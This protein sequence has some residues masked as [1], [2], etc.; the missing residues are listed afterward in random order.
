M[1]GPGPGDERPTPG[2]L[3]RRISPVV[4]DGGAIAGYF[5]AVDILARRFERTD[6][7]NAVILGGSYL[8]LCAS[9]Y[10]I[11][12]LGARQASPSQ[13]WTYFLVVLAT[14]FG[15]Y[16]V[17]MAAETSGLIDALEGM[18]SSLESGRDNLLL[19][20]GVFGSFG[21]VMLY[22][23]MLIV[24]A[25]P[26]LR[27][28]TIGHSLTETAALGGANIMVIVSVAHWEA[29][30]ADVEPYES[31]NVA[32]KVLI[33]LPTYA[34]FLLFYGSPRLL[35]LLRDRSRLAVATF[36]VESGT[37]AWVGL[38]RTAW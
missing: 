34:F 27:P 30:F 10:V 32:T 25:R 9:V 2:L 8:L 29:L 20:V 12:R 1:V 28:G 17:A 7:A 4:A 5:L 3:V 33:F 23:L 22:P 35:F 6:A 13:D 21:L 14:A 37:L 38:E 24:P 36:V 11:R 15:V 26:M 18:D 31:I 19:T 16:V